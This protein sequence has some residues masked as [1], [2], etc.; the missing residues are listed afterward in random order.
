MD[1]LNKYQTLIKQY[2]KS[3]TDIPPLPSQPEDHAI[4][5]DDN[6]RYMLFRT[7]WFKNERVRAVSLYVRLL[8]NK[9]WVEEDWTEDGIATVLLEAGVP[10]DDIVLAFH[11]PE[12]RE[13]T[14]F[15]VV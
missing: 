10:H 11:H 15:A 3:Y 4:F 1:K 2:I 13:R 12:V 9:I 8:N 5:D 6:G 7:G 14:G